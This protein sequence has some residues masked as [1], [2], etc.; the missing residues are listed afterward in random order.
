MHKTNCFVTLTYDPSRY[1]PPKLPYNDF[2]KF[3]KKLRKINIDADTQEIKPT[4]VFVT[5]EYG[6]TNKRPHWHAIIFNYTPPD[7]VYHY[8][9]D[10][11][12]DVFTSVQLTKLWG[13]GNAEYGSVTQDSANYVAR[14]A[15][16]KLAHGKDG[17]HPYDPISKKSSKHAIGKKYLE[18]FWPDVF[19][20]GHCILEDGT[21]I[22]IP[23]YYQKWMEKNRP[24]DYAAYVTRVKNHKIETAKER[25]ASD[26]QHWWNVYNNR[27]LTAKTPLT[28]NQV[29]NLIKQKAFDELQ[30]YL[31]F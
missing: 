30:A 12:H 14:Y 18:Q 20:Y 19:L 13:H 9:S 23:R 27:P 7:G 4:G 17:E 10:S 29:R 16:K 1:E 2:Q 31:K 22:P 5:G 8:T 24:E 11:G 26:E 3:M 28:R 15:A 25:H 21:E 6:E